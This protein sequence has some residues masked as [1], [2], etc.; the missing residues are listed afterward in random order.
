MQR[1][2]RCAAAT[3]AAAL[4][5]DLFVP[6]TERARDHARSGTLSGKES[7]IRAVVGAAYGAPDIPQVKEAAKPVPRDGEVR[8]RVHA[9]TVTAGDCEMRSVKT[10]LLF[11]ARRCLSTKSLAGLYASEKAYEPE[12]PAVGTGGGAADPP[13]TLTRV[14]DYAT[15]RDLTEQESDDVC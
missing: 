12:R 5:P 8:I 14:R 2:G 6:C 11:V 3:G 7:H 13:M 10:P 15:S 4:R 1:S 9:A